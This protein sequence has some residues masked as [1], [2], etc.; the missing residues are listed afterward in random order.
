MATATAA[1]RTVRRT[2]ATTAAPKAPRKGSGLTANVPKPHAVIKRVAEVPDKKFLD[3]YVNRSWDGITDFD[4]LDRALAAKDNVL[5]EGDTGTGK[6]SMVYAWAAKMGMHLYSLSSS[7]G[8]DPTQFRGRFIVDKNTGLFRWQ[9]GAMTDLMR[10]GGCLLV[11]EANFL[12][13]RVASDMFGALDKR[14]KIELVDHEG[15][16]IYAPDNFLIVA[17]LN[18]GYSGTR[19]LNAAFR[20]RF[21]VQ[22][23]FDYDTAIESQLVKMPS[24]LH[25]AEKLRVSIAQGVYDTPVSTNMLIETERIAQS[26]NLPFVVRN[27]VQHFPPDDRASVKQVIDLMIVNLEN[28]LDALVNPVTTTAAQPDVY[29]DAWEIETVPVV[30]YTMDELSGLTVND[31]RQLVRD[32]EI[33]VPAAGLAKMPKAEVQTLLLGS[34]GGHPF[35]NN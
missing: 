24:L 2:P 4:I 25:L 17:D 6:T 23:Q 16:V 13:D 31:L 29:D 14:R 26:H 12:P 32:C 19:D 34:S 20:N 9:D 27:F 18:P 3:G 1:K 10:H 33:P 15:E 35:W 7:A 28:D 11:N 22:L 30:L 5:L 8:S 21:A